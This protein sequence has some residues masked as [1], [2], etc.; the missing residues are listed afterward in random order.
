[1]IALRVKLLVVL[2]PLIAEKHLDCYYGCGEPAL[3]RVVD[4]VAPDG[5]A[6]GERNPRAMKQS[7]IKNQRPHRTHM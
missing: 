4:M 5:V 2:A 7:T 3:G 6:L 1:M